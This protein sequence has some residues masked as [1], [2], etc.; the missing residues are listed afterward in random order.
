MDF[1]ILSISA[2]LAGFGTKGSP[3]ILS[4]DTKND[5]E[6]VYA[7]SLESMW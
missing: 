7:A 6:W 2:S 3:G 5:T 1:S 4:W